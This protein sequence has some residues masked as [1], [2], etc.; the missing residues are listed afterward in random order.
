METDKNIVDFMKPKE[1][2]SISDSYFEGLV[3]K[4]IAEV[5]KQEIK[6]VVPIYKKAIFWFSSTAAIFAIF[7]TIKSFNKTNE[8]QSCNF[9]AVSQS[10]LLAYIDENIE[11][12]D[13]ELLMEYMREKSIFQGGENGD[14]VNAHA[15][16][17]HAGSSHAGTFRETSVRGW[18]EIQSNSMDQKNQKKTTE[19][20]FNEIDK[21]DILE[22]LNDEELNVE[23]L[24]ESVDL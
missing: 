22:Y 11:D 13:Q 7:V 15:G 9:N 23:D 24:Q 21:K 5:K 3:S 1:R 10:E 6:K 12:F 19:D 4:T 16:L 14:F 2:E 17:S 8:I 18:D 20:L